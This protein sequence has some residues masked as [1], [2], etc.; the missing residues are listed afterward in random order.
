[1]PR[2][3]AMRNSRFSDCPA[4][5]PGSSLHRPNAA[6]PLR[7]PTLSPI[8]PESR[9]G[10]VDHLPNGWRC[11]P[12]RRLERSARP[13]GQPVPRRSHARARYARAEMHKS[14]KEHSCEA[15]AKATGT[16][17]AA[18]RPAGSNRHPHRSSSSTFPSIRSA[19]RA[20]TSPKR[21]STVLSRAGSEPFV[22]KR[23]FSRYRLLSGR[24]S[25]EMDLHDSGRL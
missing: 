6:A 4:Y 20:A 19:R 18:V 15:T 7:S 5:A 12:D 11:D 21:C 8:E 13:G 2:L 9:V 17:K 16:A 3:N 1:M 25:P 24:Q 14:R 23:E 10:R 22:L